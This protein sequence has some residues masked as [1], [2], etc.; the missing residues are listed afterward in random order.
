MNEVD[1]ANDQT[2]LEVIAASVADAVAATAGGADRLEVLRAIEVGGLTPPL[3]TFAR[4]RAAT[5]LPLRVMLRTNGG[6]GIDAAELDTLCREATALRAAGADQFVLGFL[7]P[8]GALDLAAIGAV[9]ATI[10]P[11]RW[12][13]HHAFDHATDRRAAWEVAS[14]LPDLDLVL[15]G[16]EQGDLA[17]GLDALCDRAGW[18]TGRVRWLAGGSLTLAHIPRLRAVGIGQF[19]AG[20][21]ARDAG[22]WDRPIDPGVVR[23][24]REAIERA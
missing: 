17:V 15:S 16:G 24:L 5:R 1:E 10:A 2:A 3:E 11:C 6:F 18:A 14:S 20:R 7:T 9:L 19:H 4:I 22:R 13:L 12:T 8:D 23:A 21:A